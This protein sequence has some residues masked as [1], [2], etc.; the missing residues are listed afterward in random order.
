M[1]YRTTIPNLVINI[2][3]KELKDN[4]VKALGVGVNPEDDTEYTDLGLIASK[5]VT[6]KRQQYAVTEVI[7]KLEKLFLDHHGLGSVDEAAMFAAFNRAED[8]VLNGGLHLKP[9][10]KHPDTNKA[11]ITFFR[12]NVLPLLL[13]FA[14]PEA[15]MF[16]SS[17]QKE[18]KQKLDALAAKRKRNTDD[19][20]D[21]SSDASDRLREAD[22]IYAHMRNIDPRLPDLTLSPDGRPVH[23]PKTEQIKA[24]PRRALMKFYSR[25]AD[26]IEEFPRQVF[27]AVFVVF[28]LRPAEAA[29]RKPSDIVWNDTF[30]TAEVSSQE[31]GGMCDPRMKNEYSRRQIIIS[32][33]GMYL[34]RRCCQI[35]GDDYPKGDQAMNDAV[36]CSRWVKEL[37]I[38][39]GCDE[40]AIEAEDA[41]I[42]DDDR[43]P[44]DTN[45]SASEDAKKQKVVCYVLRRVFATN[46]RSIMGL[47]AYETDRLMG[48]KAIGVMGKKENKLGNPDLNALDTQKVIAN[49]MERYIH[50]PLHSFNP[51][52]SSYTVAGRNSLDVIEF[53]EIGIINDTD[54]DVT[55]DLALDAAEMEE[56]MTIE[57]PFETEH[58]LADTSISRSWNGC[59]R[60]VIGDTTK[61]KG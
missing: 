42:D 3:I 28:G 41:M 54:H 11:A 10:W 15:Q 43:D 32:Y 25:L 21:S 20:N 14:N 36:T 59:D 39:A 17:D 8:A 5:T 44:D 45:R 1:Y 23:V 31:R 38:E 53:S 19:G 47:T 55:L 13:P 49:K 29:A 4:K 7:G 48:H 18:I 6:R 37:L 33:W 30:C 61:P 9:S 27:F 26:L 2:T 35:I 16:L 60:T 58:H 24:L 34:L 52:V 57:M 50:D 12:K 46:C 56:V 40:S 51:A 22:I